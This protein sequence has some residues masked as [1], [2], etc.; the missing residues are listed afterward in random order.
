LLADQVTR[1]AIL[2]DPVYEKVERD[3]KLI[4]QLK[5]NL[6]Y[7]GIKYLTNNFKEPVKLRDVILMNLK[8]IH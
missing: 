2:I 7:A 5:L 4:E 1:D 8:K 3:L 6:L